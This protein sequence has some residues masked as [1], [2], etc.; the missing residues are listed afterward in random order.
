MADENT[1]KP[2]GTPEEESGA[3]N[4]DDIDALFGA[5]PEA[6]STPDDGAGVDTST[7]EESSEVKQKDI[8]ALFDA[9]DGGS[10]N[11]EPATAEDPGGAVSQSDIDAILAQAQEASEASD[12]AGVEASG[13]VS[14][15]EPDARL[16]SMGRPFDEAAAAMQAA[17]DEEAAS[18]AAAQASQ[19][20]QGAGSVESQA[21]PFQL[22]E[23]EAPGGLNV[24]VDRVSMLGD[25]KLDVKIELGS[26][27]MLVEEVLALDDGSVV[28]LDRLAGD[29]VDV[30]VNDRLI[31][32]GEVLVLND[33]FCVR[34][35][36]VLRHDPH[37]IST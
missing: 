33:S 7:P 5:G 24:S 6:S 10:D 36:E 8:D 15:P 14:E 23:L 31:A 18:A 9:A 4:Q 34:I 19:P 37:R 26:T 17:M 2:E 13:D 29:P 21:L 25:V 1:P 11:A 32:R 22:S 3:I 20:D 35:S 28:E 16:D 12:D 30:F 27:R